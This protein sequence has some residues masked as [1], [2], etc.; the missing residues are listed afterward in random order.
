VNLIALRNVLETLRYWA[1]NIVCGKIFRMQKIEVTS[2]Q[3]DMSGY[4]LIKKVGVGK[5]V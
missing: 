2:A 5:H 3:G 4:V 1:I